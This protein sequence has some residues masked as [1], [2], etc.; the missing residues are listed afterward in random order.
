MFNADSIPDAYNICINTSSEPIEIPAEV[1][2]VLNVSPMSFINGSYNN[3]LLIRPVDDSFVPFDTTFMETQAGLLHLSSSVGELHTEIVQPNDVK[4][5]IE[6]MKKFIQ[7]RYNIII[8]SR[9]EKFISIATLYL[10]DEVLVFDPFSLKISNIF[11]YTSNICKISPYEM[12]LFR[13]IMLHTAKL[14]LGFLRNVNLVFDAKEIYN[15]II[16]VES[17]STSVPE[18]WVISN[19]LRMKHSMFKN[20]VEIEDV[21]KHSMQIVIEYYIES[22]INMNEKILSMDA[23]NMEGIS[24]SALMNAFGALMNGMVSTVF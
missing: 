6:L 7:K 18:L 9:L 16:E 1:I 3:T 12:T 17:R 22:I 2:K 13:I 15:I 11:S 5:F 14:V 10:H 19:Y 20:T 8:D 23:W 4:I 21:K 24:Y